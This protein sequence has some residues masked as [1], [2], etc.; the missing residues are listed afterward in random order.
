MTLRKM[1]SPF[2]SRSVSNDYVQEICFLAQ[3]VLFDA[4]LVSVATTPPS[5]QLVLEAIS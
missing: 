1:Y 3:Y 4:A 5:P 2:Y